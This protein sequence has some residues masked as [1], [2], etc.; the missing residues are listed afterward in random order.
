MAIHSDVLPSSKTASGHSAVNSLTFIDAHFF[1]VGF[2]DSSI[3]KYCL[4]EDLSGT[5]LVSHPPCDTFDGDDE[6]NNHF[7]DVDCIQSL[8][9][10]G[11]IA[12]KGACDGIIILWDI[13]SKGPRMSVKYRLEWEQTDV[14][15]IRFSV[16]VIAGNVYKL[17]VDR[18]NTEADS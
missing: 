2:S 11:L 15:F 17:L 16:V 14:S 9:Q 5:F 4:P 13:E 12:S 10:V 6:N 3:L 8:E 18:H 7:S 1:A